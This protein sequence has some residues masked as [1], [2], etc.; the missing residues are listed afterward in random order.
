MDLRTRRLVSTNGAAEGYVRVVHDLALLPFVWRQC[1]S[2]D[3]KSSR[4]RNLKEA[5]APK[6]CMPPCVAFAR[7]AV[8]ICKVMQPN[9]CGNVA[10]STNQI[11]LCLGLWLS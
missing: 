8:P 11:N 10:Y 4:G 6:L 2:G 1:P 5:L 7:G 9:S 3:N